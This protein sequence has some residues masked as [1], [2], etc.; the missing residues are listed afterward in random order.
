[1]LDSLV[2]AAVGDVVGGRLGPQDQVVAHVL[3][4]EA[5]AV[6]TADDRVGQVHVFD[7]GLQ[8]AA[9]LLGDFAAEDD[10]DLV[11]LADRAVGVEQS[12]AQLVERGAPMKDQIVAEFDLREE[13][14][15]L[16]ARLSAFAF[17]EER[18]EAGEPFVAAARQILGRQG[19]GQLLETLRCAAA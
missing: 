1:M 16:A 7:L 4:D 17:A 18:G 14:P 13:E 12:L 10:G 9:I 6:M 11:R 15:M 2:D 5:V 8:L 3:L 19:V